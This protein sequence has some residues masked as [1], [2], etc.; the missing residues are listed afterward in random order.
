MD[1]NDQPLRF[2]FLEPF[3]GGSH[4]D[5][6][7]G[8]VAAS[9]HRIDLLTLPDRFW[10]W[11]MRGA[12][13]YLIEKISFSPPYDGLIVSS[14]MSLADLKALWPGTFPPSLIYF[15]ENQLSYPLSPGERM[16]YQYGFTNIAS[17]LAADRVAFNSHTHRQAF[18]RALPDY[19]RM[20]PDCR[21]DWLLDAIAAKTT[22]IY[23]GCHFSGNGDIAWEQK[24]RP[25]LIVWNHR[26]EHDKNP[27][28]F[29]RC[30]QSLRQS[31][32]DFRVAL[33]GESFNQ[34][35]EVFDTIHQNLGEKIVR[36]GYEPDRGAY[37]R[38]LERGSLVVSTAM[39]ENFGIAVIEAMRHGC[40]PLLPDRLSYP[41]ILPDPFHRQFLYR[42]QEDLEHKLAGIID[43]PEAYRETA[44]QLCAAMQHHAWETAVQAFDD[45]LESLASKCPNM[46]PPQK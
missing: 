26:W 10:K 31:G 25:P 9:R 45:A 28:D 42:S 24:D 46:A 18:M 13:L 16:D 29:V 39:Q 3:Y 5:V 23:P 41:E 11:R 15:H 36:F 35:P 37:Y 22:V 14:L 1:K 8:L 20:M 19:L 40:L 6:A 4:R 38:W 44:E 30:L 32:R 17:A 34:R 43:H 21:P 12:A 2:L 27:E 7:D 33:L